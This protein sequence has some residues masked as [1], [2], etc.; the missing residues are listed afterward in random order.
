[1][2]LN[3]LAQKRAYMGGAQGRQTAQTGAQS[4]SLLEQDRIQDQ[5]EMA[6][7]Q[8][9]MRPREAPGDIGADPR[10]ETGTGS[11]D[12]SGLGAFFDKVSKGYQNLDQGFTQG[13]QEFG[14]G[15]GQ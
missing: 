10:A 15:V 3:L 14:Q 9:G 11:A 1:M 2:A 7:Q 6:P 12:E 13:V 5:A 4:A 8:A